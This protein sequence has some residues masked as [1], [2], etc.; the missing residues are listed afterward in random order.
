M[1]A[2]TTRFHGPTDTQGARIIARAYAGTR[3]YPYDHALGRSLENHRKAAQA[4]ATESP[5]EWLTCEGQPRA[6]LVGAD[7]PDG[8]YGWALVPNTQGAIFTPL[9]GIITKYMGPTNY[10]GHRIRIIDHGKRSMVDWVDNLDI[11]ENHRHAADHYWRQQVDEYL[12]GEK[13]YKTRNGL[14]RLQGGSLSKFGFY[15]WVLEPVE[16]PAVEKLTPADNP[17]R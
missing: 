5:R 16:G 17:A 6:G 12:P 13:L 14:Y 9:P 3:I 15:C 1:Q 4:F 11:E 10:R 8:S 7:L 2:I